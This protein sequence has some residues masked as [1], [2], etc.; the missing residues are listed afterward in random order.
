[1]IIQTQG[2][3]RISFAVS[4]DGNTWYDDN[5]ID[6]QNN[7]PY[8]IAL[9]FHNNT[10]ITSN[11]WNSGT[12]F[13]PIYLMLYCH[14]TSSDEKIEYLIPRLISDDTGNGLFEAGFS[15]VYNNHTDIFNI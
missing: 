8:E 4:A 12:K 11:I 5:Y 2:S 15:K 10:T 6:T 14:T 1:M 13:I 3:F 7:V 9:P